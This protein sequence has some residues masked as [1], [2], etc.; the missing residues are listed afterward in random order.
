MSRSNPS[1]LKPR[2]AKRTLLIFGE[3]LGEE[4]FLKYLKGEYSFD[5]GVAITIKRG[6]G[7]S[8]V[9]IVRDAIRAGDYESKI[10]VIDNDQTNKEMGAARSLAE[11]VGIKLVEHSPCLE[12][13]F[14][15]ILGEGGLNG[16]SSS[17]LKSKFETKYLSKKKRSEISNYGRVF[18]KSLLDAKR[19]QIQGLRSLILI[20]EGSEGESVKDA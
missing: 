10:V 11:K 5:S 17:W 6:S 7:G 16:K 15:S 1:K 12:F 14:L 9:D 13:L 4:I 2:S 20:M 8:P 18:P 19:S 3:G